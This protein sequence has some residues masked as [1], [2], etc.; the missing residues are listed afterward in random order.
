VLPAGRRRYPAQA[1]PLT[2]TGLLQHVQSIINGASVLRRKR[3]MIDSMADCQCAGRHQRGTLSVR[4]MSASNLDT[5][6]GVC[7]SLDYKGPLESLLEEFRR[8]NIADED[9]T[10]EDA[11]IRSLLAEQHAAWD[12]V[13]PPF[14]ACPWKRRTITWESYRKQR[15]AYLKRLLV[16]H[17]GEVERE[18]R[19]I[20]NPATVFGRHAR[21]LARDLPGFDVVGT[22]IQ[23]WLDGLFRLVG[24][25]MYPNLKN[26]RFVREN[27]FEPDL[28]PRPVAVTFFGAC[29]CVTDGCMD[30]AIG[31]RSPFLLC[32]SCCHD[33]IGGNTEIVRRPAPL[34]WFFRWKNRQYAKFKKKD[35]GRYFSAR[36]GKQA[37]PRSKAARR[38]MDADT[39]IEIA[40]NSVD[41]DICRS[42]I[43]LDRCL[44]LRENG[45]D[46][47]YREELFFAHRQK[48]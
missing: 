9:R 3:G 26:Y 7:R 16:S 25:L 36:Y 27:I 24:W 47:L 39:I 2:A 42:L 15:D 20:V 32:R 12:R 30:Y 35:D 1:T 33:N 34:N 5:F 17:V 44:F 22:D 28:K 19:L 43:D 31:V 29:G 45:Y 8:G 18:S 21:S 11:V 37:Y 23:P 10:H 46:V 48:P 4:R 41:S 14:P 13:L 6:H 38:I 40:Q